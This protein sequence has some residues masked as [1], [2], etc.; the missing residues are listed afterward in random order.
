MCK[1]LVYLTCL[2]GL[3]CSTSGV[4]GATPFSILPTFDCYIGNDPQ[5]GPTGADTNGEGMHIRNQATRR[6]VSYVT[7]DI[8]TTRKPGQMFLNESF[9]NLGNDTG[10]VDVYGV[11]EA[12]EH[13]VAAGIN[14][15]NAP[16]VKNDPTPP[17]D[18]EVAL[19]PADRSRGRHVVEPADA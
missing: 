5:M 7:Y 9:N 1:S 10:R 2:I 12:G 19:D 6:R 16:G 15:N 18:S 17:V 4:W 13:L 14:W 3:L 8:S 11:P